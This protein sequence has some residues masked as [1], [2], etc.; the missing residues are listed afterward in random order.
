MV[1]P[2][3]CMSTK[4]SIVQVNDHIQNIHMNTTTTDRTIGRI[5]VVNVVVVVVV[6]VVDRT[7]E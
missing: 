1:I 6:V 2:A 4:I 7:C 3:H 5:V